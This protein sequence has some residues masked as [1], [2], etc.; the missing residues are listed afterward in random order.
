MPNGWHTVDFGRSFR[1]LYSDTW[2]RQAYETQIENLVGVMARKQPFEL[3]ILS[4][5]Y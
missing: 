2:D 3:G 4:G 1:E 5:W